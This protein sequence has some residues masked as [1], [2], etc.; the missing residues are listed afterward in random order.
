MGRE[1][2][3]SKWCYPVWG[4]GGTTALRRRATLLPAPD[5]TSQD[6]QVA[7]ETGTSIFGPVFTGFAQWVHEQSEAAGAER[8]LFLM[9]EGQLLMQFAQKAKRPPGWE[10]SLRT[11]WVSR[12]ACARASIFTGSEAELMAFL[13][14]LRPPPPTHLLQ[15]FGLDPADLPELEELERA[16]R[17]SSDREA[18]ATSFVELILGRPG[19]VEKV[20]RTSARRRGHLMRYLRERA[21]P[22]RGPVGLVDVGWS[23]SIQE[24]LHNMFRADDE[25]LRFHGLYLLAHVGSSDRALRG[26]RLQGYLG[27]LGTDPFDVAAITGGAEIVELVSTCAEGSLLEIGPGGEPIL[28]PAAGGSREQRSRE[29][30]QQGA[31]AY[32]EAWLSHHQNGGRVFETTGAGTALLTRVLKRFVSQ[33]NHD[34]ALA[35]SWWLH[36][37]NYGSDGTEQ[38]VPP[39]YLPTLGHRSAEDL[40]WAPMSDLHWTGGA[41]ALVDNELSDAIFFMREA[42]IDPGRFSSPPGGRCVLRVHGAG[43]GVEEHEI[44]LVRNRHG[45]TH[46]EWRIP[47]Q[48]ARAISLSPAD[49]VALL[50]PDVLEVVDAEEESRPLFAWN[51]GDVR[52]VLPTSRMRWLTLHVLALEPHSAFELVFDH[53]VTTRE[54][55]ITLAGAIF[56]TAEVTDGHLIENAEEEIAALRREIAAVYSTK[57]FRVLALP[58]RMYGAL[59]SRRDPRP[60][61]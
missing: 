43:G 12:E 29:L 17:L 7:W 25:P 51:R 3:P 60:P 10:P 20:V 57:V 31:L 34:E 2:Y 13:D 22:G 54:L 40:H 11:A 49:P 45:L 50:R 27:T 15:S 39:R 44:R 8:L 16:F 52:D 1:D 26:V 5:I 58:R 28:A 35:F 18:C 23:G 36:E 37:E 47:V 4:D 48:Q 24:S 33:P 30:V 9:R 41:A 6:E 14:R 59:R 56:P 46:V 21:G 53:E 32:Q 42:T 55:R 61:K 38:L 19:L